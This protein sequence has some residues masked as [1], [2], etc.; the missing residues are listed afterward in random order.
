MKKLFSVLLVT[1]LVSVVVF[2][3]GQKDTASGPW[4]PTKGVE[5]VVT[6]SAGGGSSIFTQ[7]IVEIMK[8][9]G[10]VDKNII[11]NY[12]TDG[13]GAV[14][15]RSVSMMKNESHTLL[16]F[17][18]GDLQPFVQAEKGDLDGF[19]PLAIM[20]LDGQILLVNYDSPYQNMEEII[21][22]LKDG[23][24]LI[25]GGSKSD[26]EAIYNAMV[27]KIGGDMEYLRS[28]STGEALTQLLGGHIDMAIA[29]PAA[30]FDLVSSGELRP[31][32][33]ASS[34]RFSG[35]FDAPTFVELGY[36]I[37]FQIFR[38]VVGPADMPEEAVAYW[39]DALSKVA[40]TEAWK[41]N[42]IDKFLLVGNHLPADQAKN[43]MQKFENMYTK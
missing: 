15:R 27:S 3:E 11:I 30:S 32:V 35:P 29:K 40:K 37:E 17:N 5:W 39:S 10:I 7:N 43:Y 4:T 41:T 2:A 38:G 6:S 1:V 24:R 19:T 18:S 33:T 36:D 9:E 16:T 42:Y 13:G 28:D 26:D 34:S 23:K 20:A 14:G 12:K 31:M 22:A 8:S 25:I 21:A